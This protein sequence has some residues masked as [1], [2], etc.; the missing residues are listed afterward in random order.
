MYTKSFAVCLFIVVL[1]SGCVDTHETT[2]ERY[3]CMVDSGVLFLSSD[4][5]YEAITEDMSMYG[6]Y[7]NYTIRDGHVLVKTFGL[8]RT[9]RMEDGDLIDPD[10]DRWVRR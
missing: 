10:G 6:Y 3:E 9:Y 5:T 4:G 8:I 7:G 2:I 1:L